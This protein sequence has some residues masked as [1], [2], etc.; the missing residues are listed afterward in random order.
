MAN[1]LTRRRFV[2]NLMAVAGGLILL[3][4]SRSARCYAANDKIN[5]ALVG[6]SGRGSWFVDTMPNMSNVVGLCDVNDRRAEGAYKQIPN[7]RRFR[8][9]R[10]M[11]DEMD[12]Q[13]DAIVVAT[14][15]HTH[16]VISAA[17]MRAGKHI[18]C[19]KPLTHDLREC[20]TL[21]Q[22]AAQCKVATQMGNQGTASEPFRRAVEILWSGALGNIREVHVWNTGGG[23]GPRPL[24]KGEEPVPQTL[25]WDLWLGPAAE[26][27][28]HS[29]WLSWHGWRDFATGNLGNW[30]SHTMNVVFKGLKIDALWD[31]E[32]PLPSA[33]RTIRIKPEVS[34]IVTEAFPRWEI[35]RYDIPPRGHLPRVQVNWYNGSG[36]APGREQ[37]ESLMGKKLDWGD[38]G[39]KKWADH[40]GC[41]LVGTKGMLHSTG[42]NASFSLLPEA[43]FKDF[44]Y[45]DPI[46]P[47]SR[48]HEQEW[49]DACKGG[50]APM[51]SFE[52]ASRLTEFNL[53]GNV[54][55][56]FDGQLDYD[57]IE[58]KIAN[59]EKAN[60]ALGRE[61]RKG[62]SL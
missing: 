49:L 15:D 18:L 30:A 52:Y 48:G 26:R 42:H 45:P 51:S 37:I 61:Y 55:T 59:N 25:S 6:L 38:A 11:L 40:A 21:K 7:A 22:L 56:Q 57:P 3:P 47:R 8:D 16:A 4:D 35:I 27:P 46:L 50:P 2:R 60:A 58:L 12:K 41:L 14:P 34:E 44:K 5:M 53:L 62:W 43:M 20:R 32:R 1:K 19:E 54:T 9:Y 23:S 33:D 28:Y 31:A 39:E 36:K 17:A 10:K 29:Q 24:P 13:I